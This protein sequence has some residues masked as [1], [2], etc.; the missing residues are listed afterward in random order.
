MSD[1]NLSSFLW[2][3]ADLLRGDYRQSDYDKVILPFTVLRRLDCVWES[4]RPVVLTELAAR[5]H[6]GTASRRRRERSRPRE[7]PS[8]FVMDAVARCIH[9]R[10]S[11]QDFLARGLVSAKRARASG[12][13]ASTDTV[14]AGLRKRLERAKRGAK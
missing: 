3:V 11:Q 2:S 9:F 5:E 4:T 12:T 6:A 8:A 1:P 7:T 14:I 10:K 13:F